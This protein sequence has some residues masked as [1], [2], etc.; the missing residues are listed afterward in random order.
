VL[1]DPALGAHMMQRLQARLGEDR[2]K[3][4]PQ[5]VAVLDPAMKEFERRVLTQEIE[6]DGDQVLAWMVSNV[7]VKRDYKD[8]IYP[9]KMG[10]KDSP[11]KIDGFMT[12]LFLLARMLE[13][14]LSEMDADGYTDS[15]Y[16]ERGFLAEDEL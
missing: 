5:S 1:F 16:D 2:V 11:N 14:P 15:V 12:I 3:Q 6:H 13:A 4:V 7:V 10:G 8:Q 9:R